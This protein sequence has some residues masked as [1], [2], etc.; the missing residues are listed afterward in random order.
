MLRLILRVFLPAP[1]GPPTPMPNLSSST[2]RLKRSRMKD[3]PGAAE[4]PEFP[5]RPTAFRAAVALLTLLLVPAVARPQASAPSSIP[6]V[7]CTDLFHPHDDPDDHLDLATVFALPEFDIKAILLDQ[8][9][10]QIRKPGRIPVE[11][12]LAMTG[13]RVPYASG[14]GAKLRVPTDKALDQPAEFQG[15][16][17]LFLKVLRDSDRPVRV[18]AVGSVRDLAAAFNRQPDLIRKKVEALYLVIGNAKIGGKEYNVDLDRQAFRGVLASKL[19][20]Y[21]FPCFPADN[22]LS[23]YWKLAHYSDLLET[24]PLP[25]IDFFLYMLHRIDPADIDPVKALGMDFRPWRRYFWGQ[26]KEMWST[27][28]ILLAAGRT[29]DAGLYHFEPAL[30]DIDNEGR[31]DRLTYNPADANVQAFVLEDVS[32]YG[33]AMTAALRELFHDF[34]V[35]LQ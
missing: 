15:A 9:D 21:W 23:S 31:T 7:Y 16:I 26:P 11:Q 19:P 24:A 14:L 30:T 2:A 28:A 17:E 10:K 25:L 12:M 33:A 6:L 20:I 8:G 32:R 18:V 29:K 22:R 3:R 5:L 35:R 1:A 4:S 27:A 34:P 13:R